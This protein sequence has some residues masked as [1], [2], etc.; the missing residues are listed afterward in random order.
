MRRFLQYGFLL[1]TL[2]AGLAPAM[3]QQ[4]VRFRGQV[5]DDKQKIPLAYCSLYDSLSR[6]SILSDSLGRFDEYLPAGNYLFR[7]SQVGHSDLDL[8][9]A[10]FRDTAVTVGL[11]VQAQLQEVTVTS[12]RI[13]KTSEMNSSGVITLSK[14]SIQALPQFVGEHDL[15]KAVQQLPGVQNGYEGSRGIFVRGGSPD[16]TLVLFDNAP[17][18]NASHIYGFISIFSPN[19]VSEVQLH[20]SYMPANYGGRL[21]S[22]LYIEPDFG[23]SEKWQGDAGIGLITAN[24]HAQGPLIKQK[25]YLNLNL[26]GCHAGFF[27]TP[28]SS[29]FF[30]V[31][32]ST[33]SLG[34]YFYDFNAALKHIVNDRH[35]LQ[36]SFYHSH[37]FYR[38]RRDDLY[39]EE[40]T[41][42]REIR[43]RK[44][45]WSNYTAT[46]SWNTR[47]RDIHIG[48]Q[49][50]LS[51]Y[52]LGSVQSIY[53]YRKSGNRLPNTYIF[54]YQNAS[55][56]YDAGVASNWKRSW[57]GKHILQWGLRSSN[58]VFMINDV[59]INYRDT[60]DQVIESDTLG[61]PNVYGSENIVYADYR[62]IF[63]DKLQLNAGLQGS[64]YMSGSNHFLALLPRAQLIY[65]PLNGLSLRTAFIQNTQNLHLLTGVTGDV[66][67]D[68]WVPATGNIRPEKGWQYSAGIQYDLPQGYTF[69]MD[70]FYRKMQNLVEYKYGYA[71]L[72]DFEPWENQLLSDGRGRAYG[73]EF[74]AAR[75][76][77]A[78]TASMKYNLSWS[79]REFDDLNAG[80]PF[81]FKYDRRHDFSVILQYKL[82]KHFDFSISWQYGS[83]NRVTMPRG[84]YPSDY[85]VFYLY[86]QDDEPK[87][88]GQGMASIYGERNGYQLPA[89]HHLDIGMNYHTQGKRV[90]HNLNVSIYNVYNR[91]NIFAI[92]ED[93]KRGPD[94]IRIPRYMQV[95]LFPILPSIAY[96]LHFKP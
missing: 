87:Y 66:Q 4:T 82:K 44:L 51:V 43:D 40:N 58:R 88:G 42:D 52:C 78:F 11:A 35:T 50:W 27:S 31:D 68:L 59:H 56:V 30:S 19:A 64:W 16:Q 65:Y 6:T 69:S 63:R 12:G 54:D 96:S 61:N 73:L 83:G 76:K 46:F 22:V 71:F 38:F 48:N 25:T 81:W 5:I 74:Y 13:Q 70:G 32:N 21:A 75:N 26:R 41:Y 62:F 37:D 84:K 45:R 47:I 85:T 33:G 77:G 28:I 89:F 72:I 9:I 55:K 15:L 57:N 8:P 94:G 79:Q 36:F 20:K 39:T 10:L 90:K 34:Y 53:N 18:Y 49:A 95:S 93:S 14:A 92:Y 29:K 60:L 1:L 86:D 3:A 67:N 23:V 2:T 17:V 24:V 80:D 91:L 7:I